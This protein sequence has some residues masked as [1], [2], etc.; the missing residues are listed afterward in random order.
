M[1]EL[2][3]NALKRTVAM[4][5]ELL[6]YGLKK[7]VAMMQI[8]KMK[9]EKI[10]GHFVSNFVMVTVMAYNTSRSTGLIIRYASC[11]NF[12]DNENISFIQSVEIAGVSYHWTQCRTSHE[13]CKGC[14][15]CLLRCSL[16]LQIG[17]CLPHK[18]AS[19]L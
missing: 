3:K 5:E 9:K 2:L 17:S 11:S 6:R 14:V 8:N 19:H 16:L 4:M 1:E 10:L 13:R 18:I 7:T 12:H 15:A